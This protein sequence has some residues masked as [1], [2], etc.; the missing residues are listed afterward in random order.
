M[1]KVGILTFNFALNYGSLLQ[2][3]ALQK[4]LEGMD[5][6]AYMIDLEEINAEN[7]LPLKARIRKVIICVLSKCVF[8][9]V[10]K[11]RNDKVNK[12]QA[13]REKYRFTPKCRNIADLQAIANELDVL[14][15]G[16]DQVWNTTLQDFTYLFMAPVKSVKK[17]G[18]SVSLG[19]APETDLLQYKDEIKGFHAI[20][21]REENSRLFVESLYGKKTPVTID[22]TFLIDDVVWKTI[23]L[24]ATVDIEEPY[25]LCFLFGKNR[26]H[27]RE[28]YEMVKSIAKRNKLKIVYLNHGY[29]KYSLYPNAL[30]DCGIEDF[31]KLFSKADMVVT[32]SFHGTVFSIIF[33]RKFYSIVD[34]KSKDRRKQDLLMRIGLEKR[35][36]DVCDSGKELLDDNIDY[37]DVGQKLGLLRKESLE[38]LK[39]EIG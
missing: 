9:P 28:K 10:I 19:N 7:Q 36:L 13:F 38:F 34:M 37:D 27:Y 2:A 29:N 31:L 39:K 17:I 12:F 33:K 5:Y 16:S 15:V 25:L 21:V 20:S 32:D 11:D 24:R 30:C 23:A 4:A 35:L 8:L 22:P 14:L 3:F 6:D 26:D 1:K 18:Y